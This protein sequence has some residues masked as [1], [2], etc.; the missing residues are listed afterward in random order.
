MQT[1][2]DINGNKMA[3]LRLIWYLF[4]KCY[5]ENMSPVYIEGASHF[6][7]QKP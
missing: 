5:P 4:S 1:S 7:E 2:A 6:E 3:V